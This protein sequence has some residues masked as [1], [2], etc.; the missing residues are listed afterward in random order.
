MQ[1]AC[2]ADV[3]FERRGFFLIFKEISAQ[4]YQYIMN[5][6]ALLFVEFRINS[7]GMFD[8]MALLDFSTYIGMMEVKLE[9]RSKRYSNTKQ[10]AT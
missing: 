4:L 5:T 3:R 9:E 6:E 8:D 1:K 2:R 10:L 7:F